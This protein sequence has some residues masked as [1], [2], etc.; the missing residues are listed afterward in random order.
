MC[1]LTVWKATR[2]I[3]H[4]AGRGVLPVGEG[5]TGSFILAS[6]FA[7]HGMY[8]FS[9]L[10]SLFLLPSSIPCQTVKTGIGTL[11]ETYIVVLAL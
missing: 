10:P 6:M 1:Y 9:M 2:R 3:G 7:S 8:V 4:S 11:A 5:A